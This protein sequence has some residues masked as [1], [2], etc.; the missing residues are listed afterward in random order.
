MKGTLNMKHV[1]HI[2]LSMW[3]RI[4]LAAQP[5]A[6]PTRIP[7]RKERRR[8]CRWVAEGESLAGGYLHREG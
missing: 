1:N 3:A 4:L 5:T 6:R 2:G 8:T 7:M